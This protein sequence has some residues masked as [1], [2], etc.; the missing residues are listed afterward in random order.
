MIDVVT[1]NKLAKRIGI[2]ADKL[3]PKNIK[4]AR[5]DIFRD[6]L[7]DAILMRASRMRNIDD[8]QDALGAAYDMVKDVYIHDLIGN[9]DDRFESSKN[10]MIK[11]LIEWKRIHN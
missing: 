10:Q 5:H 8:E 4:T 1:M 3:L 11:D 2:L 9:L 7:Y 6:T